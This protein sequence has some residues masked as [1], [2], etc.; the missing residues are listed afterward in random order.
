MSYTTD[1]KRDRE[2][3]KLN[4]KIEKLSTAIKTTTDHRKKE[5]LRTKRYGLIAQIGN[6]YLD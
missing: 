1:K 5:A 4:A 3:Q 6:L 2:I